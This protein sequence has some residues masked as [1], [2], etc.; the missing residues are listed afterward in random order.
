MFWFVLKVVFSIGCVE[1]GF[2]F[3]IFILFSSYALMKS[4]SLL[5][6]LILF[7]FMVFSFPME[8]EP[9][10]NGKFVTLRRG[11][12]KFKSQKQPLFA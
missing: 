5:N 3:E 7:L 2:W 10:N 12:H 4:P 11:D 9:H 6:L 1:G 8:G